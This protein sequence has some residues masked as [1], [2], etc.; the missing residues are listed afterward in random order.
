MLCC[1]WISCISLFLL[2]MEKRGRNKLS[3]LFLHPLHNFTWILTIKSRNHWQ[4]LVQTHVPKVTLAVEHVSK[5][6]S[7]A[8]STIYSEAYLKEYPA[9]ISGSCS[10]CWPNGLLILWFLSARAPLRPHSPLFC[11]P[12]CLIH[13]LEK[14]VHGCN[15]STWEAESGGLLWV[16]DQP[17]LL[18]YAMTTGKASAI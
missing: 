3:R 16:W 9:W 2:V 12:K 1:G 17:G 11:S 5:E 10:S 18:G 7:R 6:I 4:D 8:E 14:A 13:K 15:P